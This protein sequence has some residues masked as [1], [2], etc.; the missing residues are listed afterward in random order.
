MKRKLTIIL[1]V[2]ALLAGVNA[3]FM[4]REPEPSAGNQELTT[5]SDSVF[6]SAHAYV[7]PISEPSYIPILN[8]SAERPTVDA[9]SAVIYDVRAGRLLFS[10]NPTAQLP[11]ASLTKILSAVVVIENLQL[12]D[13]V[14]VPEEAIRVDQEK[15]DLFA[16]EQITVAALLK[17]MLVGS[18]NDAA[19]A[20]AAHAQAEGLDFVARMNEK[21]VALRMSNSQFV[22]PAGLSDNGYS[23]AQ[24]LIKLV[25]YSLRYDAIWNVLT[26]KELTITSA[27]GKII[28]TVKNTDQLLG[29]IP[30]IVGGKTGYTE[31][32]L[33]CLILLVNIPEKNDMIVSIVLKSHDRFG[34]TKKLV[35]W[36]RQAYRW[37]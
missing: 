16:G 3:Y 1:I 11:I 18:S 37:E 6:N 12:D 35:E 36:T 34:D 7:L 26:E 25:R 17:I 13:V 29:I 24:D 10:K 4:L 15:Q 2:L 31:G 21:A 5:F 19:Y 22:D 8:S 27:D 23:S 33:G 28:H 14:T 9:E 32:A 20:L 30:D